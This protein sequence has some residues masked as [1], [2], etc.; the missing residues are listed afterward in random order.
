MGGG[1]ASSDAAILALCGVTAGAFANEFFGLVAHTTHVPVYEGDTKL[2]I[3]AV[4]VICAGTIA[5][6][7]SIS[8]ES[9]LPS[10]LLV[11]SVPI[12]L[13]Y[14]APSLFTPSIVHAFRNWTGPLG[15]TAPLVAG[16]VFIAFLSSL[17]H[18]VTDFAAHDDRI[19]NFRVV[20]ILV[21]VLIGLIGL[22]QL[23]GTS[24]VH[25]TNRSMKDL[26]IAIAGILFLF[27]GAMC[28]NHPKVLSLRQHKVLATVFGLVTVL[29][30]IYGVGVKHEVVH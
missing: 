25:E 29:V 22:R 26:L 11:S 23:V 18:V 8:N 3:D 24:S 14:I 5:T 10:A 21:G 4:A 28:Y 2:F 6:M 16:L 9:T 27:V 19:N 12:C 30:A 13:A 15:K 1:H 17:E 7:H 20:T